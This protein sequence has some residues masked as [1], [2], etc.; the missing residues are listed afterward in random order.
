[1]ATYSELLSDAWLDH[2]KPK[3][4]DAPTVVSTFAGAGGSTLGYS[5]AGYKELMAVEWEDHAASCYKRNFP[6]VNL[7]H[8]DIAKVDPQSLGL[9]PGELDV[10]DGSP[11]CQGFS[12]S[13]K[14]DINDPRNQLFREFVRLLDAWQPKV[15]VMENVAAMAQGNTRPLFLEILKTLRR[16]GYRVSA[17]ILDASLLGVPQKRKRMIFIGVR[18]DLNI[19]PPFPKPQSRIFTVRDAIFDIPEAELGSNI[20]ISPKVEAITKAMPQG[21]NMA[22]LMNDAGL[23]GYGFGLVR[24]RQDAPSNTL[25]KKISSSRGYLHPTKNRFISSREASRIQSFPDE[26]DWGNSNYTKIMAR[27]G[28]SVPPLMMRAIAETI[29]T[30]VLQK[31]KG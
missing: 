7:F 31:V 3:A 21:K 26:Y 23:K 20:P 2:K 29:E 18:A 24:L 13:G 10:F 6:H 4:D 8:G 28:N 5:M 25:I 22:N 12:R 1:M 16:S 14:R 17:R 30:E 27:L 9:A 15:F 19:D 11:P